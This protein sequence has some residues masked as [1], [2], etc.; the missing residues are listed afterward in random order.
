[1]LDAIG[2]TR[3]FGAG[4]SLSIAM[5]DQAVF[6]AVATSLGLPA[7]WRKRLV[8]LF[9]DETKLEEALRSLA[10]ERDAS[11]G[12]TAAETRLGASAALP[13]AVVHALHA[14]DRDTLES[15]VGTHLTATGMAE[16][17]R[18]AGHIAVR[19]LEREELSG[20]V[21]AAEQVGALRAFLSTDVGAGDVRGAIADLDLNGSALSDAVEHHERRME[22]VEREAN[23]LPIR[24]HGAF[25]RP[26]DYYTG[27]VF[28]LRAGE[29]TVLAGGG[30]YDDL[31]TL[32]GAKE[33][34]PA[35]GFALYLDRFPSA[36]R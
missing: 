21:L 28:E 24:F 11:S 15:V 1:M 36:T 16:G 2:L 12:G 13:E 26:L 18:G 34:V 30:R 23:G 33:P 19:L 5:G 27:V 17:R 31:L 22:L 7:Q 29:G 6:E 3:E 25:G 8:H 14:G 32:L 35:V 10:G 9:G 20:T 4:T